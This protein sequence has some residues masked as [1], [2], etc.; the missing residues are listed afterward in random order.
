M[1]IKSSLDCFFVLKKLPSDEEISESSRLT[2]EVLKTS[3]ESAY[4]FV[5]SIGV[6]QVP[7]ITI[8]LFIV[9]A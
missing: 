8:E 5:T 4:E 6:P 3:L 2:I 9:Y 7:S 1:G